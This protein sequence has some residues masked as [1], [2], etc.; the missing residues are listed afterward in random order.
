MSIM[1]KIWLY[2]M[3]N[4]AWLLK[5]I[6][7]ETLC[8]RYFYQPHKATCVTPVIRL[9]GVRLRHFS[10]A[11]AVYIEDCESWWLSGCHSLVAAHWLH[12]PGVLGLILGDYRPFHFPPFC[13]KKYLSLDCMPVLHQIAPIAVKRCGQYIPLAS[14]QAFPIILSHIFLQNPEKNLG[15]ASLSLRLAS[16]S[17]QTLG[18][19]P[20]SHLSPQCINCMV[21]HA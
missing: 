16:N 12:K 3:A 2:P 13:L 10:T 20:V 4:S 1:H 15:M 5:H 17:T 19:D 21:K 14:T 9:L 6:K 8:L 7:T 18:N 11:C